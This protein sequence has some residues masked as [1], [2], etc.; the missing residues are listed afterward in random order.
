MGRLLRLAAVAVV[1]LAAA[2]LGWWLL[3][4]SRPAP[5]PP[6]LLLVSIDALRADRVGYAG[7]AQAHTPRLD[8]LA[9]RGLTFTQANTPAPLTLPAHASLHTGTLPGR[10]GVRDDGHVLAGDRVTLAEV[11]HGA[12]YRTGGFVGSFLLDS[13]FGLAQG[14]DRYFD[15]FDPARHPGLER[16]GDE[17]VS[18]ALAWLDE[19]PQRPF[20]A[21]VHLNDPHAPYA[22]P[23]DYSARFPASAYDAEVAWTDSLV[24]RLLDHLALRGLAERTWVVVAG[25][26]GESLGEH[27]E[28]EHGFFLYEATLRVPL[29]LV[30]P[31]G[32][33]ATVDEPVSLVDVMP[34]VVQG[35]TGV[36]PAGVQGRALLPLEPGH[37]PLQPRTVLAETWLPRLH[38]GWS[39]LVSVRDGRYK[40]IQAPRPELYDL[41]EDPRET[42][43]LALSDPTRAAGLQ[44]ILAQAVAGAGAAAPSREGLDGETRRRLEALGLPGGPPGVRQ[45]ATRTRA[46]PKDR[47]VPFTMMRAAI[48]AQGEEA[49]ALAGRAL[50]EDPGL[51]EAHTLTGDLHRAAGRPDAALDAYRQAAALDPEDSR[52]A[53][54]LAIAHEELGRLDEA[55]RAFERVLQLDPRA[56]AASWHLAGLWIQSGRFAEAESALKEALER[57]GDRPALLLRLGECYLEMRR[58]REAEEALKQ[59]LA[60]RPDLPGAHRMLARVHEALGHTGAALAEYEAELRQDS[61][62][63]LAHFD[64]GRLL[65]QQGRHR[66]AVERFQAGVAAAPG[67]AAGHLQLARALLE[68]GDLAGARAAA[69]RALDARP[70]P[71]VA[72]LGH[73]VLADVY[74]RQGRRRD[75]ARETAAARRLES[76]R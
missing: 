30:A 4:P 49:L 47:I 6:N 3:H 8:G 62:D 14:F 58:Y 1:V 5:P 59:A 10:H 52:A 32:R 38:F 56:A 60:V 31:G 11:L 37:G 68:V 21:W 41:L 46:D 7:H 45:L 26:H 19:E 48:R 64:L 44:E 33:R 28:D 24:G 2:A 73:R 74:A 23:E 39:E 67:F 35:L 27:G 57:K 53:L 40:L 75:A 29:L 34:T 36:V 63:P 13:R 50:A 9:A 25:D 22:A 17:V 51:V 70:D 20:F 42:R 76:G 15:A 61:G 71:R 55:E 43:D 16:R 69:R 12:G 66:E 65:Q 72:A 18:R 54:G